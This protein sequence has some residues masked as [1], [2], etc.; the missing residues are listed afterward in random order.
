[1][2]FDQVFQSIT[3]VSNA[4]FSFYLVGL[5]VI[6][7]LFNYF[8]LGWYKFLIFIVAA[9]F[10][11][12]PGAM[13][14]EALANAKEIGALWGFV[15][16]GFIGL[17]L[18]YW[19]VFLLGYFCAYFLVL[20]FYQHL[21]FTIY[22]KMLFAVLG[23]G[24][25]PNLN[26]QHLLEFFLWAACVLT[27]LMALKVHDYAVIILSAFSGSLM[28]ATVATETA[29]FTSQG[30]F[31]RNPAYLADSINHWHWIIYAGL[32]T[33]LVLWGHGIYRQARRRW[34]KQEPVEA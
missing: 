17:R 13:L 32:A 22:P 10:G 25:M 34:P 3:Q 19:V 12:I 8:G 29:M 15:T 1:M 9:C 2:D 30:H 14:G 33:W 4:G 23:K 24:S 28:L 5:A 18:H 7:L 11:L 27:G 6:G 26:S 21:D 16:F 20:V 31:I